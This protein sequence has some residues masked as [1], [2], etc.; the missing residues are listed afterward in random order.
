MAP[1][2]REAGVRRGGGVVEKTARSKQFVTL[3]LVLEDLLYI[4]CN[5]AHIL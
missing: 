4:F 5:W 3:V 2:V 1:L